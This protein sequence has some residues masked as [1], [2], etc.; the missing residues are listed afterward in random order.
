MIKDVIIHNF[1]NKLT[2]EG[3]STVDEI[4]AHP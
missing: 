4:L 2:L 3:T 1:L